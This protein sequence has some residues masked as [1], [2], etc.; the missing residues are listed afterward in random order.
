MRSHHQPARFLKQAEFIE[1]VGK[2]NILPHIQ[3]AL[4]RAHRIQASFSGLG[5]EVARDLERAPM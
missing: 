5:D 1:H 3:S 4:R 2:E